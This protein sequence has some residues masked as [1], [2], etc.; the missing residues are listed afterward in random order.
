MGHVC[1][2]GGVMLDW[3]HPNRVH[4]AEAWPAMGRRHCP[5]LAWSSAQALRPAGGLAARGWRWGGDQTAWLCAGGQV[6]MRSGAQGCRFSLRL[7]LPPLCNWRGGEGEAEGLVC[8]HHCQ[9]VS[10]LGGG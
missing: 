8:G 4:R 1:V 2:C 9:R 7:W 5:S 3:N 6:R 10:G